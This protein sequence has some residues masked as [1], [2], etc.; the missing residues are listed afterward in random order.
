[1]YSREYI[2]IHSVSNKWY[3]VSGWCLAYHRLFQ[4]QTLTITISTTVWNKQ[5][6]RVL[7]QCGMRVSISADG[8]KKRPLMSGPTSSY[9]NRYMQHPGGLGK[10]V[11]FHVDFKAIL[12]LCSNTIAFVWNP[13]FFFISRY[14]YITFTPCTWL[15]T[16]WSSNAQ[17]I[18][19]WIGYV[20]SRVHV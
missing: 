19:C 18:R 2:Q 1:M 14:K 8:E 7:A 6:K 13:S 9:G 20:C 11:L 10:H 16:V 3:T 17:M 15:G 4:T 12:S 5:D